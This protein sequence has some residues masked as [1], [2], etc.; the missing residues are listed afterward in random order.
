MFRSGSGG[1][2]RRRHQH[3]QVAPGLHQIRLQGAQ[4]PAK[5]AADVACRRTPER[6][7]AVDAGLPA[8]HLVELGVMLQDVAQ[9]GDVQIPLAGVARSGVPHDVDQRL[10]DHADRRH[11]RRAQLPLV[12]LRRATRDV[13]RHQADAVEDRVAPSDD[14]ARV[15]D[16]HARAQ[17]VV[18]RDRVVGRHPNGAMGAVHHRVPA[19]H[20]ERLRVCLHGVDLAP[21]L[22]RLPGVVVV[23]EG[24]V[25]RTGRQDAGVA[26]ARQTRR[27]GVSEVPDRAAADRLHGAVGRWLAAVVH[28]DA[29]DRPVV[30]LRGN[31]RDGPAK[32]LGPVTRRN[33]DRHCRRLPP[34]R[35]AWAECL[36]V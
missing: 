27:P 36:S 19:S 14:G 32:Q 28:D 30:V 10:V 8:G 18:E 9:P 6:D 3:R 13:L 2:S 35:G 24:D 1:Q 7:L 22:E 16:G 23:T 4:A 33:N 21:E 17:Q 31:G 25:R 29:V 5:R 26:R 12:V 34:H 11:P 20:H 15:Q